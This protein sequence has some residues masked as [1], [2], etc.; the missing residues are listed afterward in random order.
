MMTFLKFCCLTNQRK[1]CASSLV[2][3]ALWAATDKVSSGNIFNFVQKRLIEHSHRLNI[4]NRI[5]YFIVFISFQHIF[6][7]AIF[8]GK[9]V[10][11]NKA[12]KLFFV[13]I[14]PGKLCNSSI[15]C[16]NG[17]RNLMPQAGG[18]RHLIH[19]L[20]LQNRIVQIENFLVCE[21]M[22]HPAHWPLLSF[23]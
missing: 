18:R 22:P 5:K 3:S 23:Q 17:L 4:T 14:Y 21:K 19:Y 2:E 20:P 1:Y 10:P 11:L 13:G 9:T 12:F 8:G 6:V 15:F 16:H 7:F